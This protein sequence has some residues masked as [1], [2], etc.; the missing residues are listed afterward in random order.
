MNC[1]CDLKKQKP[2]NNEDKCR[3]NEIEMAEPINTRYS[4]RNPNMMIIFVNI[5]TKEKSEIN[6][7]NLYRT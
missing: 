5:I 4:S 7:L 3:N 2:G 1:I 6:K